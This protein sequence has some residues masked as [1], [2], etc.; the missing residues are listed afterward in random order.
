MSS[1]I[2]RFRC[3]SCA[4]SRIRLLPNPGGPRCAAGF[5]CGESVAVLAALRSA[6]SKSSMAGCVA[7]AVAQQGQILDLLPV[8]FLGDAID[9]TIAQRAIIARAQQLPP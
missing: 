3:S 6:K 1:A 9:E 4:H 7:V 5:A 2:A 8:G